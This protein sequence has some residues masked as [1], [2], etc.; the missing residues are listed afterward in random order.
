MRIISRYFLAL[1]E[2]NIAIFDFFKKC[3]DV[4]KEARRIRGLRSGLGGVIRTHR[5]C[6]R[7]QTGNTDY[8]ERLEDSAEH[9][10]FEC[11]RWSQER[12]ALKSALGC[13]CTPVNIGVLMVNSEANLNE[14]AAYVKK[15]LRTKKLEEKNR[16]S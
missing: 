5:R 3:G 16:P 11:D 7:G 2:T 14:T 10:F 15:I 1:S 6:N 4:P 12:R 8:C 9:T 13:N